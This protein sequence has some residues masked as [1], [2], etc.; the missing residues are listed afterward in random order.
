MDQSQHDTT[1]RRA[2]KELAKKYTLTEQQ[3]DQF[4]TYLTMLQEWNKVMNLTAITGTQEIVDTHFDDS[5]ELSKSMDMSTI[6]S[7]AD[8]GTGAGFPGLALKI[9][10]PHI[11]VLLIEVV[12]KKIEFLE[13]VIKACGIEGIEISGCDWR[14]FLRYPDYTIDL[15]VSRA[16]LPTDELVRMFRP[17]C[18]YQ[19]AQL[20]YWASKNWQ[21]TPEDMPYKVKEYNYSIAGKDRK[22]VFFKK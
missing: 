18:H 17:S 16:A 21:A 20:V 5:L 11:Q 10:F 8:V 6:S 14:N 12:Q 7:L 3:L 4:A 9:M 1:A 19:H 15:F 22:L 13:A 2:V